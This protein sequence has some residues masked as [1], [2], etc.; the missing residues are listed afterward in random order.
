MNIN[1]SKIAL[2]LGGLLFLAT[3]FASALAHEKHC[4]IEKTQLGSAMKDMKSSLRGYVKAFKDDDSQRMQDHMNGLLKLSAIAAEQTPLK[5]QSMHADNMV[6]E[7]MGMSD[8]DHGDMDMD[9]SDHDMSG[10]AGM[11]G[12]NSA[13]HSLHMQYMQGINQLQDLFKSLANTQDKDEIKAILGQLKTHIRKSH[14]S[15]RQDCD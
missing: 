14:Q 2:A 10:M 8:M 4:D 9:S 6:N 12:M 13:Q 1:K 5:V 11:E 15:F 7:E 3:P